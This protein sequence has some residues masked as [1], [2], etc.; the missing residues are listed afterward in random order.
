MHSSVPEGNLFLLFTT[1]FGQLNIPYMVT[2]SVAAILYGDIRLTNDVD[3]VAVL[4]FAAARELPRLFAPDQFYCPPIDVIAAEM[5]RDLRGHFNLIHIESG[6]KADVY[7]RGRDPLHAWALE[8]IRTVLVGSASVNLAPPEYVIIRK[9]EYFR[10]G[11]SEK[12]LRDIKAMIE[13]SRA[14]ID[15]AHLERFI[16]ERGLGGEW[17]AVERTSM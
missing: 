10:E 8:R 2:G 12:H 13:R 5:A 6:F 15:F 11:G 14:E 17:R 1:R 7:L 3:L 16:S 4:N 9:L